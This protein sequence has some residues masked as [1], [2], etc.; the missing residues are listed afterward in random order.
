MEYPKLVRDY[1]PTIIRKSGRHCRTT[2][3]AEP[4]YRVALLAK[5]VEE[6]KEAELASSEE[7]LSELADVLEVLDALFVANQ[8]TMDQARQLQLQK[9]QDRGGFEGRLQLDLIEE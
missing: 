6:A 3:L 8:F 9:R 2:I 7:L 5:L 4:A 1:I